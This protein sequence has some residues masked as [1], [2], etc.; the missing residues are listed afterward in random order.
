MQQIKE[1][2]YTNKTV[3]IQYIG[4]HKILFYQKRVSGHLKSLIKNYDNLAET[5]KDT[6]TGEN[7]KLRKA[8]ERLVVIS[9][10]LKHVL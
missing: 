8:L 6:R 9:K 10:E 3:C 4:K 2:D 1:T 5:D 7:H